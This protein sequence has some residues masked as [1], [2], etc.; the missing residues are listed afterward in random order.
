MY[1]NYKRKKEIFPTKGNKL[2]SIRLDSAELCNNNK[3]KK[4]KKRERDWE[5]QVIKKIR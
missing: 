1:S 3:I 5:Y 2:F 4:E